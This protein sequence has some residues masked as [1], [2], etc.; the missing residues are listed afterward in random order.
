[1]ADAHASVE[2]A[3]ARRLNAS[4][5]EL[6]QAIF[7][8]AAWRA[9]ATHAVM[10]LPSNPWVSVPA[11]ES[12]LATMLRMEVNAVARVALSYDQAF[13][14]DEDAKW[15]LLL[16]VLGLNATSQFLRELAV[17]GGM[18]VIRQVVKSA[19]S[20]STLAT[21][22]KVMLKVYG[23]RVTRGAQLTKT[24]PI[25]GGLIGGAWNWVELRA[26]RRRV[27]TCFER[28]PRSPSAVRSKGLK[29][30]DTAPDAL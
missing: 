9:A 6:A 2:A 13:F 3:R 5:R 17:V 26:V 22:K 18:G 29:P 27:I 1:M 30:L 12:D 7:G 21:F 4:A 24:L 20:K 11:A 23:M 14:D 16:P 15:E 10:S 19:L 28:Q 8:G 25:V